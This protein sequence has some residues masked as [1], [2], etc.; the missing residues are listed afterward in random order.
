MNLVNRGV[1]IVKPKPPFLEWVN[2]DPSL[3]PP[4]SMEYLQEDC[5]AILVPDSDSLEEALAYLEDFK[6]MLFEMELEDW[7]RDRATWPASR[8]NELFDAWFKLEAHSMVW[9]SAGAPIETEEDEGAMDI[10]G[11]WHVISSPDFDDDYLY[12]ETTPHVTLRQDG[13]QVSGEFHIGLIVGSLA[14]RMDGGRVL[15]SFEAT[16]EMEPVNGAGTIAL[17]DGRLVLTLLFHFGDEFTF[18]CELV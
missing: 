3:A 6:P 13:A 10:A 5:T 1:V 17:Q 2:S 16:D 14:G 7:N 18:E 9:D 15:F 11:T 12:M 4:V 8:T